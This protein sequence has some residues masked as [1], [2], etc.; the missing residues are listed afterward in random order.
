MQLLILG[1]DVSDSKI[2]RDL[3]WRPFWKV[4]KLEDNLD[5]AAESS[6]EQILSNTITFVTITSSITS[7]CHSENYKI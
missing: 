2:A 6:A 3:I 4:V 5:L 1:Q 7:H